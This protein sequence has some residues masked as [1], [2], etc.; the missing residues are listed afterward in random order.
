M[1]SPL[2]APEM[3]HTILRETFVLGNQVRL[4]F[5]AALCALHEIGGYKSLGKPDT[6]AYVLHYYMMSPTQLYEYL[7]VGKALLKLPQLAEA[8]Q[9]GR[10]CYTVLRDLIRVAEPDGQEKWLEFVKGKTSRQVHAEVNAALE[11]GRKLPREG[12]YGIPNVKLRLAMMLAPEKHT[13]VTQAL[14]RVSATAA[15]R[16]G[17]KALKPEDSLVL[18]CQLVLQ[19]GVP[20][21]DAPIQR[22][23]H[24]VVYER[25]VDCGRARVMTTEGFMEVDGEVVDA[26]EGNAEKLD[27]SDAVPAELS[28]AEWIPEPIPE[29]SPES[30]PEPS[31]EP[32]PQ[33]AK[34]PPAKDRPNTP[35]L[36]RRVL[37]RDGRQCANPCCRRSDHLHCHHIVFRGDGGRTEVWNEVALCSVCHAIVHARLLH[38]RGNPLVGLEFIPACRELDLEIDAKCE[39]LARIAQVKT[40]R[41]EVPAKPVPETAESARADSGAGDSARAENG[42]A[43]SARAESRPVDGAEA[44][45]HVVRVLESLQYSKKEARER[46]SRAYASRTW[47]PEPIDENV[48][49]NLALRV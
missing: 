5:I 23:G 14:E 49:F 38:I 3:L 40:V 10:I 11:K 22:S 41:V 27:I 4:R 12:S 21:E 42:T 45:P 17:S 20:G 37:L 26:I 13:L 35:G 32:S 30:S 24:T 39:E 19:H 9:K 33:P 7:D 43:H 16:V 48:L 28:S 36:V 29:L 46:V 2:V 8:F 6:E 44:H 25:C 34:E 18:L 15:S 47:G 31:P 1:I